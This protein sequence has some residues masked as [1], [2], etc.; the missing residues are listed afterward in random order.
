MFG[1]Y[2]RR[3]HFVEVLLN[4]GLRLSDILVTNCP[5]IQVTKVAKGYE[6]IRRWQPTRAPSPWEG[7]LQ[8]TSPG[9]VCPQKFPNIRNETEALLRMPKARLRFLQL[10]KN[11]LLR[12]SEDCLY[13]NIFVPSQDSYSRED[14]KA[15]P[16]MVYVHG[17]SFKWGSG[18]LWDARILAAFGEVVVITF[19]YRLGVLGFLNLNDSPL[20]RGQVANYG[21]MDQMAVLQWI[22]EN[23]ESFNG[24]SK[25]VTLFGHGTGAACIEYLAHSPTTVPG[26][27]HRVILM[28]GSLFA[29]WSRVREPLDYA[30]QL[31]KKFDCI[32]SDSSKGKRK[33]DVKRTFPHEGEASPINMEVENSI[34]HQHNRRRKMSSR[35]RGGNNDIISCLRKKSAED[36]MAIDL[37]VP[38][39]HLDF[40]PSF[41]GVTIKDNF[42]DIKG[43]RSFGTRTYEAI[44]GVVTHDYFNDL[45][46]EE[47]RRGIGLNVRDR[48]LQTFVR[49]Q[50]KAHLQEILLTLQNEYT[51]WAESVQHPSIVREQVLQAFSDGLY[52]SPAVFSVG[53]FFRKSKNTFFYHF[54]HQTKGGPFSQYKIGSTHGSELQYVFGIPLKKHLEFIYNLLLHKK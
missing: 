41:D 22:Q 34:S 8:A 47:V 10:V 5:H 2:G 36:L 11:K 46:D 52:V 19:N 21:I 51:D 39:F 9:P 1:L 13:L 14:K 12:Q 20:R 53:T 43:K 32:E 28:S 3:R 37:N 48:M 40:G 18:N 33:E 31:A 4:K 49:N 30:L 29:P 25:R 38:S 16:V 23:A 24:D 26:L 6:P 42:A 7:I 44:V 54:S 15:Y 45:S 50:Y 27:F 35:L 17:E